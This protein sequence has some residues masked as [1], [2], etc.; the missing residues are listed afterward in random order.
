MF[1]SFLLSF[2]QNENAEP[3]EACGELFEY[4]ISEYQ[5]NNGNQYNQ[6][7]NN[8]EAAEEGN[9]WAN[10]QNIAADCA[11]IF[12]LQAALMNG[13]FM[14][15]FTGQSYF[16]QNGL[17]SGAIAG[18]AIIV[19]AVIGAGVALALKSKKKSE[20]EEPVFQGGSLS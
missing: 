16:D 15:L 17:S 11:E 5:C 7:N 19:I 8:N 1:I 10:Q 18:I 2:F 20:L 4:S 9:E 12:E 13:S 14:N 3:S 6:Y